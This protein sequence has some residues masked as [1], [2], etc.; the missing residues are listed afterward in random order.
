VK[1]ESTFKKETPLLGPM[2]VDGGRRL[3][4]RPRDPDV[5]RPGKIFKGEFELKKITILHVLAFLINFFF[6]LN[7]SVKKN[8]I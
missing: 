8:S 2:G 7:V 3:G 6:F 5:L 4:Q 1:T